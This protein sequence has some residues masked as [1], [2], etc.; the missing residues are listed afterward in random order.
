MTQD[1]LVKVET[2]VGEIW[3]TLKEKM[4]TEFLCELSNKVNDVD[5]TTKKKLVAD[6]LKISSDEVTEILFSLAGKISNRIRYKILASTEELL[7]SSRMLTEIRAFKR[8][9]GKVE[10]DGNKVELSS[11]VVPKD[12]VDTFVSRI[13]RLDVADLLEVVSF[14][15]QKQLP[16]S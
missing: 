12:I 6:K 7:N 8:I 5:S 16:T 15:T 13:K 4:L 10:I 14:S 11:A 9:G 2:V 1:K 3:M